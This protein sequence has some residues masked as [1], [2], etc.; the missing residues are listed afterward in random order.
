MLYEVVPKDQCA[1]VHV[2]L[3]TV[4]ETADAGHSGDSLTRTLR[5]HRL[6]LYVEYKI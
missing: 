2:L 4:G 3:S 6:Y 1:I 5:Y